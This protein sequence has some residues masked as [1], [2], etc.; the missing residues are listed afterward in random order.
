[1]AADKTSPKNIR[2]LELEEIKAFFIS[3]G[4]AAFRAT[5]VYEWLWKKSAHSFDD[6]TNLPKATREMLKEN[7]VINGVEVDLMQKVRMALL[8]TLL[9]YLTATK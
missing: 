4:D 1:M 3:Q 2:H 7:F 8:K 6:M 5:Q 9:S